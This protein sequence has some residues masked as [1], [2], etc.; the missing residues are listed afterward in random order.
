MTAA[1][2]A[3]DTQ[4]NILL[5]R[6]HALYEGDPVPLIISFAYQGEDLDGPFDFCGGKAVQEWVE[7]HE[8]ENFNF[9]VYRRQ[10]GFY[11]NLTYNTREYS[12]DFIARFVE[13]YAKV[14]HG[15]TDD[16]KIGDIVKLLDGR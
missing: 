12:E 1:E 16:G 10:D 4:E 9:F 11:V 2:F 8:D 13:N 6:R 14:V 5:C 15:L 3:R 7:D